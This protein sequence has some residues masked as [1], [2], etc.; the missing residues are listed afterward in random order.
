MRLDG[1]GDYAKPDK[2]GPNGEHYKVSLHV[3]DC[4]LS[5][6]SP[7]REGT[8]GSNLQKK[9]GLAQGFGEEGIGTVP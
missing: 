3:M 8:E 4:T 5:L 1:N 7:L 9:E 2:S 6:H